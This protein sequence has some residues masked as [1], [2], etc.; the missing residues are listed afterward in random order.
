MLIKV[1]PSIYDTPEQAAEYLPD[2]FGDWFP[3]LLHDDCYDT[4]GR[5]PASRHAASS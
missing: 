3:P 2:E 4:S 1:A 5:K